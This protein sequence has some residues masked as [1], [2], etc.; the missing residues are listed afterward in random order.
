MDAAPA[1]WCMQFNR[2][3]KESLMSAIY[4]KHTLAAHHTV[5]HLVRAL[6]V[7]LLPIT[8]WAG[9]VDINS[10]DAAT[11]AKELDGVGMAR[12]QAIVEYR[13]KNGGFGSAEDLLRVQGIGPKVLEANKAN[14]RLG[15][16]KSGS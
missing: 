9:P 8:T 11:L 3:G 2:K 1:D 15:S 13:Q 12:A 14:I 10:A 7:G 6:I 16:T 4:V 5:R